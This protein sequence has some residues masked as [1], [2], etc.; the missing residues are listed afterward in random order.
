M[1]RA[2]GGKLQETGD[3]EAAEF[4]TRLPAGNFRVGLRDRRKKRAGVGML[5]VRNE[6]GCE[7]EFHHP[8]HVH[9]ADP[10]TPCEIPRKGQVMG[11]EQESRP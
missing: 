4:D 1:E 10:A 7:T 2:T 8:A 6:I 5:R 9:H 3:L 11:D